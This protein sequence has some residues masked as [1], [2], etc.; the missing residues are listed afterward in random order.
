MKPTIFFLLISL[1]LIACSPEETAVPVP[2]YTFIVIDHGSQLEIDYYYSGAPGYKIR[3]GHT[4][5]EVNQ[6]STRRMVNNYHMY[7]C[8]EM[9]ISQNDI[10]YIRATSKDGRVDEIKGPY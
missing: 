5:D 10:V 8:D 2:G 1:M 3:F 6:D 9:M 4:L 7:G